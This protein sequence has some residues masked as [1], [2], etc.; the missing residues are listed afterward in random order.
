MQS[1]E[2]GYII[3]QDAVRNMP[4][5]DFLKIPIIDPHTKISAQQYGVCFTVSRNYNLDKY[6]EMYIIGYNVFREDKKIGG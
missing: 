6:Y 4:D 1:V 5:E 3:I 2:L